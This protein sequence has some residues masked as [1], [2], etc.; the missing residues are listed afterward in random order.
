MQQFRKT[1]IIR[2]QTAE[3]YPQLKMSSQQEKLPPTQ[4]T[5]V[6]RAS[7]QIQPLGGLILNGNMS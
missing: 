4:V 1:E 7:Q 3:K 2:T 5:F 6:M